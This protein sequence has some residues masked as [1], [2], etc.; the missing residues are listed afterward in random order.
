MSSRLNYFKIF[1]LGLGFMVISMIWAPY[2]A[3]MPIFLGNF[4]KSNT[5]IRFV[6]SWDNIANLFI[7]PLFGALSDNTETRIGRRMPY[8]LI[9][10]PLAGVLY[11]L[12]PL[13]TKLLS[14]LVI[15]FLFN[16]VVATYRTPMVAL[17]PDIVEEEHRS[18]ANGVINFMGGLGSLIIVFVGSQLYKTNKAYPFFLSGILSLIIPII[19]FL[20][21][22]E[23]K[24]VVNREKERQSILKL[25]HFIAVVKNQN[26]EPL[27]L[28]IL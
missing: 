20:T 21:I 8:I 6:M 28:W 7:L 17:M 4:T 26:K 25:K 24:I 11:A 14:L 23:S 1:D 18:K 13:R 2:N 3:Y 19:L 15:D 10:M 16:I 27:L 5:L 12:I 22:K 9:N